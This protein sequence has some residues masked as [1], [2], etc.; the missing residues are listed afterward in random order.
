ME[1]DDELDDEDDGDE[2][3]D[4]E[5]EEREAVERE[6]AQRIHARYQNMENMERLENEEELEKR[7]QER[8]ASHQAIFEGDGVET[9]VD[10]QA[11]HPTVRDP[12]LWMVTVKQG[13]ERETVVC[14]MQKAINMHKTG[15]GAMAIK[16]AAVQ[17][18]LKCYIYVEAEREAHVKHALAGMRHVYHSKAIKLVPIKEMVDS[19]SVTKKKVA[20]IVHGSWVRMRGGV[21]KGDLARVIDVNYA[22]NQCTVKLVPRF[23]YAHLQAK[24]EGT[25]QG[26]T[27]PNANIRPPA[28]L[29]TEADARRYNLTFERSRQ[30]RR[31][32]DRVDVLCGQHKLK[33]G[34]HVKTV[35]MTST[36]LAESPA[37]DEL[38]RYAAGEEA[39]DAAH[40]K[41]ERG[42]GSN[43]EANLEALAASLG[44][45]KPDLQFKPGDQVIVVD[46]D[47]KNLEGVVEYVNGDGTVR[48]NPNHRELHES[49]NIDLEQLRK[50]FKTGSH[51]RCIN[52][53]HEGEAGMVVKVEKDV[54]TVFSDVTKDE[55]VVF[56][57]DLMDSAEAISRIEAIGEYGMHDLAM[58]EDGSVGMV[59][60]IEKDAAML[61]MQSSTPDRPDIRAARLHDMRRRV[62]TRN[63][64]AVDA[65]METIESGSMVRVIDGPGKGLTLTVQ[66]IWKGTVFGKARDIQ[67]HGGMVTV[68]ARHCRIH[69]A[70]KKEG[71]ESSGFGA[72]PKSPGS[73][74]LR[75]PARQDMG[76]AGF[77]GM[78]PLGSPAHGAAPP[79]QRGR[80]GGGPVGRRDNGLIGS[81]VKV[82]AG[83]YK[84]Y[85][86]KVVDATE[87]TV[88]VEL[89]AQ[90]RTVTVQRSQL[91]QPNT[92]GAP[93]GMA[94]PA[95]AATYAGV[96]STPSA[97]GAQVRTPMN[98]PSTP[99]YAPGSQTP[100]RD[101]GA[102]GRTPLRDSAWNPTTPRHDPWSSSGM[103]STPRVGTGA[104]PNALGSTPRIG[105]TPTQGTYGTPHG[106][107]P[108][109]VTP[110]V[111][112][113]GTSVQ[114][115]NLAAEY[116]HTVA[117]PGGE[118]A[119]AGG[120]FAAGPDTNYTGK[121]VTNAVVVLPDG[122]QGVVR[123][124][125]GESV[126]VVIGVVKQL[127]NG[128]SRL[129]VVAPDAAIEAVA[130]ADLILA[131]P[132]KKDRVL[133][134]EGAERGA[135]A[136]LIGVDNDDGVLRM[137]ASKDISIL[138]ISNLARVWVG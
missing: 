97:Y 73:A 34:Y 125:V 87:T 84:G 44:D 90:A 130:E 15:K 129:D 120:S 14:L 94:P 25:A 59:V 85:K 111:V 96:A 79:P 70:V 78:A 2:G 55:F 38:Q 29:F 103:G 39:T 104:T 30:D 24:E 64:S 18:H 66:H 8:Y 10:Q 19:I 51:V 47:L 98:Y 138:N 101:D 102:G 134:V 57:H 137:D 99:A 26:R 58:L 22:D 13:K 67:D 23:D 121:F 80:F 61:M 48:V 110:R 45:R 124:R 60:R 77:P 52:G 31:L 27:K 81:V 20:N 72:V 92:A 1:D 135:G 115:P 83:V 40:S 108:R 54:A 86:G 91:V 68:R 88:R 43:A 33:D 133:V 17:D 114:S 65:Q 89:Q 126:D 116:D 106:Y 42:G 4:L 12:K 118:P 7:L 11:L 63:I 93:G 46:G 109:G 75:S 122:R 132:Q 112:P 50:F 119:G 100:M 71:A 107:T 131:K 82:S 9:E 123:R 136:E 69:G 49:L 37:L 105:R 117:T 76:G 6:A 95:S 62:N 41:G 3:E 128:D 53:R 127:P 36:K 74:L 35:S 5:E 113:E 28:R 32:N 21:Y 16:S 56:M